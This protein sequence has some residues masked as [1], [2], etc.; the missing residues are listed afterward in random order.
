MDLC[1]RVFR[2]V[3]PMF[4]YFVPGLRCVEEEIAKAEARWGIKVTAYPHWIISKI[5]DGQFYTYP[6]DAV[7]DVPKIKLNDIYRV[8]MNVTG[9]PQLATGAKRSD[10][11]WRRRNMTTGT[12]DEVFY[13]IAGW[14]KFDVLSYL[15]MRD[16]PEPPSSGKSATGIDLSVPSVLWLHDTYPDDF[17]RL[18]EYFPLAETIVY[19]RQFYGVGA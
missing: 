8:H 4:M 1:L 19:R 13:P 2:N 7:W 10:S 11:L 17:G 15:K 3:H 12:I 14:N 9:V 5:L 16:I 18:C 6:W